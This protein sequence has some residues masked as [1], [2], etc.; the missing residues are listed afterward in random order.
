ML[1][2]NHLKSSVESE[3]YGERWFGGGCGY[4]SRDDWWSGEVSKCDGMVIGGVE[5]WELTLTFFQI[6]AALLK[7][8]RLVV[9][10]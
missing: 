9:G 7:V 2:L 10:S 5:S 6:L 3:W 4:C 1:S 8:C